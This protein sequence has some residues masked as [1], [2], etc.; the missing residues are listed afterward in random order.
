MF[1]VLGSWEALRMKNTNKQTKL[2]KGLG[3]GTKK[4]SIC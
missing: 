1:T 2:L 4:L 3:G